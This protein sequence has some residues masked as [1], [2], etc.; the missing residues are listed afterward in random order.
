[1]NI[2]DPSALLT[3]QAQREI[4]ESNLQ[5]R[6]NAQA[7][8]ENLA[9]SCAAMFGTVWHREN[10]Q[11]FLDSFT[12]DERKMIF[13]SHAQAQALLSAWLPGHTPP[14]CPYEFSFDPQTG[15]VVVGARK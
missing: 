3:L 7:A 8:M 13:V 12:A 5:I 1:M 9:G 15:T 10:P 14:V 2:L 4:L 11:A 6:R